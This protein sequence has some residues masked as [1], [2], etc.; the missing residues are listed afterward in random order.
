MKKTQRMTVRQ[1]KARGYRAL[2]RV[3]QL[4]H[5]KEMMERVL[6]DMRR[7]NIPA[8]LVKGNGGVEVWRQTRSARIRLSLVEA[9]PGQAASACGA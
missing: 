8:C 4:P 6:N 9:R 1:A 5:E 7:A 3:C 2:T